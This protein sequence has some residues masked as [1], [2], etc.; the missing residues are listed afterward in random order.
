MSAPTPSSGSDSRDTRAAD[1]RDGRYRFWWDDFGSRDFDA[2]DP[3]RVLAVLPVAAIEQ[4]GPHLPV[5]TDRAIM[6]GMLEAVARRLPD[7]LDV[8][9]LPIQAVGKSNEH[10]RHPGTLSIP[11]TTLIDHWCALG[12]SVARAGVRKLVVV[13]S[14]GGN[15]DVMGIVAREL[16]ERHD[17]LV[18]KSS[19]MRFGLPGSLV[20]EHEMRFGI[21]GGDYET[22]LM[23]H[24]HPRLVDMSR[25]HDFRSRAETAS[26]TFTH[27]GPTG[28]HAWAWLAG[29][30]NPDGVVGDA[31]RATAERGQACL[32]HQTSGFVAL[33]EELERA[34]LDEWLAERPALPPERESGAPARVAAALPLD[35][36]IRTVEAT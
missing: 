11:A 24:L 25:A 2:L 23:L 29:D 27:I 18:V 9:V 3:E 31:A 4:H 21:H 14:H 5:A 35:R 33:L 36:S 30:L 17:M 8:R 16:R 32:E 13:N 26:T 15:E 20:G 28:T 7:A 1:D 12:A 22:S 19:W 6:R 34:R 10:L